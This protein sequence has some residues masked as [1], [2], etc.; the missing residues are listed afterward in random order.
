MKLYGIMLLL[1]IVFLPL[2]AGSTTI[3]R[4]EDPSTIRES[5]NI[6]SYF[7]SLS[8]VS[9]YVSGGNYSRA[10]ESLTDI[11]NSYIPQSYR[12]VI[13]RA[14]S[15][16]DQI[17]NQLNQ[18]EVLLE[19]TEA[20]I[21]QT[22]FT[23]AREDL[24]HAKIQLN[25]ANITFLSILDALSTLPVGAG[26]ASGY[27][28]GLEERIAHLD[29]KLSALEDLLRNEPYIGTKIT[30]NV[31]PCSVEW[32]GSIAI[33][34]MLSTE[35]G[36]PIPNRAIEI[37]VGNKVLETFTEENGSYRIESNVTAYTPQVSIYSEFIPRGEDLYVYRYSRSDVVNITVHYISAIISVDL[38]KKIY[39]PGETA[40]LFLHSNLSF[41]LP[42][43]V[44]STIGN[45]TGILNGNADVA[46]R[47]PDDVG[48]GSYS[49]TLL[50]PPYGKIAPFR[51]DGN[52]TIVKLPSNIIIDI[53]KKV[54]A[55]KTYII[56]ATISPPSYIVVY[57]NIG[58]AVAEGSYIKFHVPLLYFGKSLSF[59]LV[60]TPFN[61]SYRGVAFSSEIEVIN[62]LP[63]ISAVLLSGGSLLYFLRY[64]LGKIRIDIKREK[65][66]IPLEGKEGPK[67]SIINEVF[68]LISKLYGVNMEPWMTYREYMRHL[69][70]KIEDDLA[71]FISDILTKL[72]K[73]VYGK[74]DHASLLKLAEER[75]SILYGKLKSKLKGE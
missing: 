33:S 61:S 69:L 15:L 58:Q 71:T 45:F 59:E 26:G 42:F 49:L 63:I 53:P 10:N 73:A 6:M 28:S 48:E 21:N 5:W 2:T 8:Y 25:M 41:P 32:G 12:G 24:D 27:L 55:G 36:Q 54:I 34:G 60:A 37:H 50:T 44:I 30:I 67:G 11:V 74:K 14:N 52:I 40:H 56:N 18:T 39:L 9:K 64:R 68:A 17:L 72:E 29:S 7:S 46:L 22:N 35:F 62:P 20:Y 19:Q 1:F 47:I 51:W 31:K 23:A 38:D 65:I 75:A 43:S 57:S 66:G 16:M 13:D 70:N 3:P 4:H